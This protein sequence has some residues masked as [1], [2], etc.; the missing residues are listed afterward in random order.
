MQLKLDLLSL[1]IMRLLCM[2]VW[3]HGLRVFFVVEPP[4]LNRDLV[5]DFEY[6]GQEEVA[7][8]TMPVLPSGNLESM[9]A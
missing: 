7:D 9:L 2:A 8:G 5:V 1:L 3:T 6:C 4:E